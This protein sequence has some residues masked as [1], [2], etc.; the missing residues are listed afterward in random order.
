MK[1]KDFF[2]SM[3]VAERVEFAKAVNA[4]PRTLYNAAYLGRQLNAKIAVLIEEQ[5]RGIVKVEELRPDIKWG[6][7]R[8][9]R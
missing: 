3:P 2:L 8:R 5:T 9:R 1:F 4:P 7:I 6:V